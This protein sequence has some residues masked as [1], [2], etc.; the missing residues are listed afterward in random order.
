MDA[1]EIE[2]DAEAEERCL[3]ENRDSVC[4]HQ[5]HPVQQKKTPRSAMKGPMHGCPN[6]DPCIL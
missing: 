5:P 3:L 2:N 1:S 4:S 6:I